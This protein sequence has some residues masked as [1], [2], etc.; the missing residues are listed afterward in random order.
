MILQSIQQV[1][2]FT[3]K[4]TIWYCRCAYLHWKNFHSFFIHFYRKSTV[5]PRHTF[6]K[7]GRVWT[8][9]TWRLVFCSDD[10]NKISGH[11]KYLEFFIFSCWFDI[12]TTS[13]NLRKF[14]TWLTTFLKSHDWPNPLVDILTWQLQND[15]WICK[16]NKKIV[17]VSS[18]FSGNP[19]KPQTQK[20]FAKFF[21][22]WPNLNHPT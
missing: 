12:W 22:E 6:S 3:L 9:P 18:S 11:I 14:W 21:C 20:V 2:I 5:C 1:C 7:N 19:F 13:W 17:T 4:K 15:A 16:D 10:V 8:F